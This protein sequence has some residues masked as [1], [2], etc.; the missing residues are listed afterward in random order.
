MTAVH[1]PTPART[2]PTTFRC[3]GCGTEVS[4]FPPPLRCPATSATDDV[5]HVLRRSLDATALSWPSGHERN[6]FVRYRT[7]LSAYHVARS[8][9]RSDAEVV[10]EIERLDAAVA[11]IDGRGFRI[12]PFDRSNELS[13]LLG[14]RA[15]GGVLVKDETGN[16]GGSHKARHLFGTMLALVLAGAD[17]E[18]R[19]RPLAIAS[20][21]NAALAA[22][23]VA[24]AAAWPIEVFVPESAEPAVLAR[25]TELGAT[26]TT[27]LRRPGEIGDPTY[28]RLGEAV[29]AGS[30]PF[31]C[32]G[33]LNALAIE[34]GLTLGY[35]IVDQLR[36]MDRRLDRIVVQVGGGALASSI[37]GACVDAEALGALDHQPRLHGLQTRNAYPLKRAYDLVRLR[38]VEQLD[39]LG[40]SPEGLRAAMALPEAAAEL[41]W[42]AHHRSEFMWPWTPEPH[43]VAHGILDDETYDWLAVV[44]GMLATGGWPLL[45]GEE[46]L[47][48]ANELARTTTDIDVD[49]TGSAALA[50]LLTLRRRGEMPAT[51]SVAVLFTGVR[52]N[53]ERS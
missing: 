24:R 12:T 36:S 26:V 45:A 30:I 25:L 49:P 9:G 46:A 11:A 18:A 2:L 44:R 15:S 20:C 41:E 53:G 23:I 40:P 39:T 33:N 8:L 29:A 52:R 22:A 28:L 17:R 31:T 37:I 21:G 19:E 50:G 51:E 35:E 14:F 42:V 1:P 6:P 4:A 7:L 38:L 34:G 10:A 48:D 32:Q 3:G 47:L 27:C 13:E 16:V 5:D 43:S